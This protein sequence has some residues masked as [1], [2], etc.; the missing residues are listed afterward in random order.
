MSNNLFTDKHLYEKFLLYSY[1]KCKFLIQLL[2]IYISYIKKMKANG[3][4]CFPYINTYLPDI[5]LNGYNLFEIKCCEHFLGDN[6]HL[7]PFSIAWKII[8]Y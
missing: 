3:E 5:Y 8:I 1:I 6:M 7:L 4:T 2:Q